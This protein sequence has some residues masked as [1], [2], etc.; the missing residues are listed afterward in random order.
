MSNYH[1][2]RDS[3]SNGSPN[4]AETKRFKI[5]VPSNNPRS[6][7]RDYSNNRRDNNNSNRGS[8]RGGY[9]RG[10]G[11]GGY[12][13]GE[14]SGRGGYRG[15]G[16]DRGGR[17]GGNN[18]F[19]NRGDYKRDFDKGKYNNKYSSNRSF[20][21]S[22]KRDP[23]NIIEY[24]KE[25]DVGIKEFVYTGYEGVSAI[26][27]HRFTDFVV[28]E[29]DE[30]NQLVTIDNLTLPKSQ[31]SEMKKIPVETRLNIAKESLNSI[32]GD[33]IT[34]DLF[35]FIN[36]ELK[37]KDDFLASQAEIRQSSEN[38]SAIREPALKS[39]KPQPT[40][41]YINGITEKQKRT[42][43]Y[44]AFKVTLQGIITAST[45][46]GN[47]VVELKHNGKQMD[48]RNS[49][50]PP[51][52][53]YL[54]FSVLKYNR[55]SVD[56]LKE[57][58]TRLRIGDKNVSFA[59]TKDKRGVTTQRF[60]LFNTK[61][62]KLIGLNKLLR[63][64][65]IGNFKYSEKQIT[66]GDLSG[67]RF[68]IYLREI[69]PEKKSAVEDAIKSV[70]HNGFI[71]YFG[72]QRFGNS[73][74]GTHNIGLACILQKWE[75]VIE[76]IMKPR[77]GDRERVAVAREIWR[78]TKDASLALN[79]LPMNGSAAESSIL[80]YFVRSGKNNDFC[81]A[82]LTIPRNLRLIYVHAYQ[83]YIWN[84][85][86]SERVKRFGPIVIIGD[87]VA[88]STDIKP[89]LLNAANNEDVDVKNLSTDDLTS[90]DI[91][92]DIPDNSHNS[93]M[94]V[95]VITE[96]NIHMYNI[97]DVVIPTFGLDVIYPENELKVL[98]TEYL[99]RDGLNLDIIRRHPMKEF[100]L[101][102]NYR[103]LIKKPSNLEHEWIEY[104]NDIDFTPGIEF[105]RNRLDISLQ[106]HLNE[107]KASR[108]K[109]ARSTLSADTENQI[110]Q[111]T[112]ID[113][114]SSAP[115]STSNIYSQ[116]DVPEIATDSSISVKQEPGLP[117]PQEANNEACESIQQETDIKAEI[118]DIAPTKLALKLT[119]DLDPSTY[120]TM[121][122]RE[123]T[124]MD[125]G[126]KSPQNEIP[127]ATET[128]QQEPTQD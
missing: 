48:N 126:S 26:F 56:V 102:G 127:K 49:N 27:K 23:N 64:V 93:F 85:I 61:A 19:N 12:N 39:Y 67:N 98:Y 30:N 21:P 33:K 69:D 62:T 94:D 58:A 106:E 82:F 125:T 70:S 123:L 66:L 68:E 63:G 51:S 73:A 41:F 45:K 108:E 112:N 59:G 15:R 3:N 92:A 52:E 81:G 113:E 124:H 28:T 17:G 10:G 31:E 116:V 2:K 79:S 118:E 120:A 103:F 80:N 38:N 95:E 105:H 114:V 8:S 4:N 71:N 117:Q 86:A 57:I 37:K 110:E 6:D 115:Q 13:N 119:F 87:V 50:L 9:S 84:L 122:I 5:D 14:R 25:S 76:L 54:H 111:A 72:L 32:L 60:S 40:H 78:D 43:I 53:R 29:I 104:S 89:T 44:N 121:L 42:D 20:D 101:P 55:E 24:Y 35:D 109:E 75:D 91:A 36:V 74:I 65:L 99:E 107:L 47:I 96:N 7:N 11:R 128:N 22:K 34:Q 18:R 77:P 1:N 97:T 83:S 88:K 90:I 100:Q 46:D 16:G